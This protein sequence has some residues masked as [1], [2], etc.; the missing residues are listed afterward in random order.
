FSSELGGINIYDGQ[1]L[2]FP[3]ILQYQMHKLTRVDTIK[4]GHCKMLTFY[5]VDSST[6]IPSTD[7]VLASEPFRSL[8]LLVVDGITSKVDVP[9][10]L[11]EAKKIRSEMDT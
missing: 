1:C 4:S 9:I 8:P 3:N 7:I 6:R 2:E 5:Y 10:S 11:K